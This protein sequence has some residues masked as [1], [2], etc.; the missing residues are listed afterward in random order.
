[1]KPLEDL[2]WGVDTSNSC[3]SGPGFAKLHTSCTHGTYAEFSAL[4]TGFDFKYIPRQQHAPGALVDRLEQIGRPR[5]HCLRGFREHYYDQNFQSMI[6]TQCH[7][8]TNNAKG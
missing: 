6:P 3:G 1:M 2:V 4:L 5:I 8:D 7:K